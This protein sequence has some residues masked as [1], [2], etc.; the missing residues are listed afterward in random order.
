[1]FD[2]LFAPSLS[3]IFPYLFISKAGLKL[4]S[5]FLVLVTLLSVDAVTCIKITNT[6]HKVRFGQTQKSDN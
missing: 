5:K 6:K 4:F 2:D 1:M 3:P